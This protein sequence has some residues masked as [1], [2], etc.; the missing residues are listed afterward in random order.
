VQ[1]PRVYRAAPRSTRA[2][3]FTDRSG[4]R[5]DG[6]PRPAPQARASQRTPR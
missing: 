2:A 4:A 1:T 6:R 3:A 5:N